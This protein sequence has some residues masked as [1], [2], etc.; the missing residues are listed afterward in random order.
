MTKHIVEPEEL[1]AYLDHELKPARQQEVAEHVRACQECM[2]MITD[3]QRVS[4]TLQRWQVEPAPASLKPPVLPVEKQA[5]RWGWG[6]LAI[7]LTGGAAVILVIAAISIPNLLRSRLSV[8]TGPIQGPAM[9]MEL[10]PEVG[11]GR[12]GRG[13]SGDGI[14]NVPEMTGRMIAYQ[15]TMTVEVK[16]FDPA[17]QAILAIVE[18]AGGYVAQASSA[19]TPNQPRRISLV[20][21]VPATG[22]SSILA[23]IRDLGRVKQEHLSTEEVTEQ[24]VDLE[25]RLKNARATEQRLIAVLQDRTG[26]VKDILEVERE[27]ARTREEIERMEAQRQNLIRRVEMATVTLTLAEE[28]KAQLDPTPVGTGTQL[29]NALVDGYESF[30]GTILALVFF[31]ARYGLTL[32]FW[33]GLGWLTW[34][35]LRGRLKRLGRLAE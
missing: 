27:I 30:V 9:H 21:R 4:A 29:W 1:Q 24:V 6:R 23:K 16:E 5:A 20:V 33:G 26:K 2:T 14:T 11:A 28:F 15:V 17:K 7:G 32:L 12:P 25:A 35:I 22:L 34:R 13:T 10:E 18:Q 8:P 3:L 31:V 19:E